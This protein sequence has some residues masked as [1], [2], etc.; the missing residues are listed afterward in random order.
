M[1]AHIYTD[2]ITVGFEQ[3]EF[4]ANEGTMIALALDINRG[5]GEN[6]TISLFNPERDLG[7]VM[8]DGTSVPYCK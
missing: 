2:S 7:V 5:P 4:T 8:T 1:H 6:Q 3:S